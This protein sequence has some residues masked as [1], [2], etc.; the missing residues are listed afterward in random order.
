MLAE[1]LL[2]CTG[3]HAVETAQ[4]GKG[5]DDVLVLPTLEGVADE[6]RDAPEEADDLAMVH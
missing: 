3:E 2:L 4:D 6:V 5:Q 1:H